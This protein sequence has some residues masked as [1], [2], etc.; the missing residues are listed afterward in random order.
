[1][2]TSSH[3]SKLIIFG[4]V[5]VGSMSAWAAQQ[6]QAPTATQMAQRYQTAVQLLPEKLAAL[7]PDAA[8]AAS[9]Q[10]AA[11]LELTNNAGMI[12]RIDLKTGMLAEIPAEASDSATDSPLE[13]QRNISPDGEKFI[14]Q[15]DFDLLLGATGPEQVLRLTADGTADLAYGITADTGA[16]PV[17]RALANDK[18]PPFGVWSPDSRYF[19]TL[20]VDQRALRAWPLV[21][22]NQIK[23]DHRLPVA[24]TSRIAL[25]GDT[26]VPSGTVVVIDTQTRQ[27]QRLAVPPLMLSYGPAPI[28]GI[29]WSVDSRE[30]F[31]GVESRDYKRLDIHAINMASKAARVVWSE[32]AQSATLRP[33]ADVTLFTSVSPRELLIYSERDGR[34][35]LYLHDARDGRVLRRLTSGDWSVTPGGWGLLQVDQKNRWVYFTAVGRESGRD[36]YFNHLYRIKIDVGSPELLTPEDAHHQVEF[37]PDLTLFFDRFSTPSLPTTTVVRHADGRLL[38]RVATV[39]PAS[40]LAAGRA[41]PQRFKVMAADG[42]T[43]LWGTLWLPKNFDAMYCVPILDAI[44][45]GPQINSTSLAFLQD[46]NMAAATAALGFAVMELDARGTP[47]RD[48]TFRDAT[49]GI[50]FGS[51][52]VAADHAVAVTQLR[53]RYAQLHQSVAGMYG[54]SWGGYYTVRIMAQRPDIFTV[55]VASAGSHNNYLYSYEH[56][57]WF[58]RPQDLKGTYLIQSNLPLASKITGRLLLAHGDADD[59]VH[60]INTLLMAGA[61]ADARRPFD[62]LMLPDRNHGSLLES[63]YFLERRWEYFVRHLLGATAPADFRVEDLGAD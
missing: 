26:V 37:S 49:W 35:H 43:P 55:G 4:V 46:W 12:R 53:Q 36:P 28:G 6:C 42:K 23:D 19:A 48:R 56:D 16:T 61:L 2:K 17:S 33:Y 18:Q 54:H 63:G 3:V 14:Q 31:V 21:L 5:Q 22:A 60:P 13:A 57:R 1:M 10:S 20:L 7:A 30:L 41:A 32:V 38:T 62:M 25:P 39:D 40:L 8:M 50:N 44:Y 24:Y 45:A 59:D 52:V 51:E 29:R 27:V 58:G 15:S 34:G 47:L 9:W 11:A